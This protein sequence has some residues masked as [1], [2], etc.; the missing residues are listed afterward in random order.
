MADMVEKFIGDAVMAAWGAR[1]A[2]E[3]DA[4]RAVRAALEVINA[5]RDLGE[6]LHARVG[7]LT[8]QAAVTIGATDQGMVAGDMVNTAA[9]LQA[10]APPD[11]VLVS[12]AT[13]QA[14]SG[15]IA[16]EEA[17]EQLLKGKASP[18]PAWRALRVVGDRGGRGRGEGLDPP[19]VGR[20]LEL[21]LL[22]DLL[23]QIGDEQR[24]RLISITGP[25]GIGKSRLAWEF[26]K[27]VDGLVEDIYWHRGR[28]PSYGEGLTFWALGEMVRRRARLAEGDDEATTR[29]R[30]H[31]V[32]AEFISGDDAAWIERSLLTLLG[33]EPPPPG[34]R[35]SLFAAWRVFFERM[36]DQHPTVMVFEDLHWAD[37]GLLDFI[38]HVL[39]WSR[40]VPLMVVALARPELLDTRPGWGTGTRSFNA[41]GL[42]PLTAGQMRDLL[43][44]M[45]PEMPDG[46]V[47]KSWHE[48]MASRSTRSRCCACSSPTA[49]LV[50][51]PDGT[52]ETTRELGE[53]ALPDTLRALVA[54][55]LDALDAN[56]RSLLQDATIL[57]QTFDHRALARI[58]D[59]DEEEV[60]GQL[61]IL[62]QRELLEVSVD[63]RSPDRGQYGFVQAVIREVAYDTFSRRDR[64]RRHLA[65]ARYYEAAGDE[66][67]AGVL[68]AHYLGAYEASDEGPETDALG[69]QARRALVSAAQRALS[70]GAPAQALVHLESALAITQDPVEQ[71]VLLMRASEA[72]SLAARKELGIEH[73]ARAAELF[74]SAGDRRSAL[75]A[76]AL[77]AGIQT[78]AGYDEDA[79]R[80]LIE[81][82][83]RASAP[84]DADIR[85]DILSR[86]S[87]VHMR[88][89]E[90]P[91]ALAAAEEAL[92]LAEPLVSTV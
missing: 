29:E 92:A 83:A 23:H 34:G 2:N 11:T 48:L 59:R 85:A 46:A 38:D 55:R 58:T 82:I 54:S 89:Q 25:A 67:L 90:E 26:E 40:G 4:E 7:V 68:A 52:F 42:E 27:Y 21:R 31:E 73:A 22:K 28:S 72:A 45:V 84:E 62:I 15:A 47:H 1:N 87:R 39:E 8:G 32:V 70:L 14:A 19:F 6:G 79:R 63:P 61:R 53:L 75:E 66:E 65:A 64:R 3:D 57:G 16:F 77:M 37:D 43:R 86:L 13:M 33:L 5:V 50:V 78:D 44:G 80:M 18:V 12:E 69:I 10:V 81:A 88:L 60:V 91:E 36:A 71:A 74:E 17:G 76:S 20:D 56:D 30:V 41:I 49:R 51:R 9:R 35:E 24:P